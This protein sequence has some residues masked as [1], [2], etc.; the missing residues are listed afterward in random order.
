MMYE[1][2]AN[3]S[4][5]PKTSTK[6]RVLVDPE[7]TWQTALEIVDHVVRCHLVRINGLPVTERQYKAIKMDNPNIASQY[8]NSLQVCEKFYSAKQIASAWLIVSRGYSD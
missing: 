4:I 6:R 7:M 3:L 5:L 2:M 1:D 8:V